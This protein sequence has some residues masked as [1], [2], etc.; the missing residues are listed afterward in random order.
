MKGTQMYTVSIILHMSYEKISIS[1]DTGWLI[2]I[3]VMD[4]QV[5]NNNLEQSTAVVSFWV[6]SNVHFEEHIYIYTYIRFI[7][8]TEQSMLSY[9]YPLLYPP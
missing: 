8:L 3:P 1:H 2:C 5:T 4:H 6:A 7:N 9:Q